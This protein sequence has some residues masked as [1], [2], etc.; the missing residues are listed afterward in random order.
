MVT[1]CLQVPILRADALVSRIFRLRYEYAIGFAARNSDY[2]IEN[3]V[4]KNQFCFCEFC[5]LALRNR[6]KFDLRVNPA[7]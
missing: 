6:S 2:I 1:S 7:S 5:S 3:R 4:G